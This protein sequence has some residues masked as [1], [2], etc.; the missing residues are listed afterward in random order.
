MET[1]G[2]GTHAA[3]IAH[4][5]AVFKKELELYPQFNTEWNL[6]RYC[7]ARKH[8]TKKVE[9]M[10]REYFEWRSR[11]KIDCVLARPKEH[12][13]PLADVHEAGLYGTTRS[14]N[15]IMIERL[16]FSNIKTIL[17]PQYDVMREDYLLRT[18]ERILTVVFPIASRTAG[19]RIDQLFIIY[20]MRNINTAKLFDPKF[21]RFLKAMTTTVQS[22]YPELLGK[23][24][25]VN[26][27][28]LVKSVW[29][30]VRPW[31]DAKTRSKIEIHAG[32]PTEALVEHVD[33]GQ[34]PDFLGG[35]N[36]VALKDD[37]GPWRYYLNKAIE[38]GDLGL[39]D[40]TP[41]LDYFYTKDEREAL[42]HHQ[43]TISSLQLINR[44]NFEDTTHVNNVRS[45]R[46]AFLSGQ[47]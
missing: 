13:K 32:I 14:G 43:K 34:L 9:R 19:R 2:A 33:I 27:N 28:L 5:R 16:G 40:N 4:L 29:A 24:F 25:V 12:F 47:N 11:K 15:P 20:D 26:A 39:G 18:Y 36:T 46:P 30:I 42:L 44:S 17:N 6:L 38:D 8:N 35:Q 22:Y 3:L 23:L 7:K 41:E 37:H 45:I 31:I 10:L 1:P 21:Q